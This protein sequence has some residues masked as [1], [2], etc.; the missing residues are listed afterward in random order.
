[1]FN[2]TVKDSSP[3]TFKVPHSI[4]KQADEL[5]GAEI[6]YDANASDTVDGSTIA[7]CDPPSGSM[8]P[9]GLNQVTCMATDKSGNTGQ[10]SFSVIVGQTT[11]KTDKDTGISNLSQNETNQLISSELTVSDNTTDAPSEL[12]VSDNTTDAPSEL[13]VSDNTTDDTP[14]ELTVSDNTTDDTPSVENL[15]ENDTEAA[16]IQELEIVRMRTMV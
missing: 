1:M 9:L 6:T 4:L 12:T 5:Q 2:V 14:S 13:T 3:P 10:A 15:V 7:T 16:Q 11:S 8:F